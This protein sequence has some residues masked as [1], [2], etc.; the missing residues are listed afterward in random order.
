M[1]ELKDYYSILG[2]DRLASEAEIKQAYRKLA[3]KHH[4]DKNPEESKD[5]IAN[6]AFQDINEAY[7]TLIDKTRRTQYNKALSEKAAGVQAHTVQDNQADMAYRHGVE[8]YK[9]NQF[10]RAVEYFR[11][12]AKLN[13]KKAIYYDR[14]GIAIIKAGGPLEEAKMYCDKA[15]QMEMYNAE[16]Y[17]SLGIIYQLA[18]MPEKAK[19]QYKEA[20]KWDPN[21]TQARQRYAIVEKETK[22]GLFGKLF[23]K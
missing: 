5:G 6:A 3:M 4:P 8:A 11:A 10:K 1:T 19:E 12:A 13:P 9:A 22:K 20:L 2:V 14:L 21:N 17:L 18:G 16:H 7:H 23:K 15:I